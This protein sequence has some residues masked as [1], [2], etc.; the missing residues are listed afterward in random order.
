MAE[1]Q[2]TRGRWWL[3]IAMGLS[4]GL[5]LLDETAVGVALP[6]MQH[7]LGMS[8]TGGHWVINAYLLV[9]TGLV[10]AAGKLGD[11]LDLKRLFL[12]GLALFAVSSIL[13]GFAQS[14]TW[15]IVMRMVQGIGAAI[16]FPGCVA[17]ISKIFKPEERGLAYGIQTGMAGL[18]LCSGPL[19][20]GS[21]TELIS[22]RWIFWINL[23]VVAF[24]SLVVAIL[25]HLPKRE[26]K[27]AGHFDILGLV[28]LLATGVGLITATMQGPDWGWLAAPTLALFA[29]GIAALWAFIK[30]ERRQDDPLIDISLFAKPFFTEA[31]V[32]IFSG[33]FSKLTVV[34]FGAIYLQRAQGLSPIDAGLLILIGVFPSLPMA[35][36]V[37][38]ISDRIGSGRVMLIGLSVNLAAQLTLL[39][40]VLI[41]SVTLFVA[42]ALAWGLALPAHYVAPRRAAMNIVEEHQHGQAGGISVTAQLLGGT[43]AVAVVGAARLMTDSFASLFVITSLLA[44]LVLIAVLK[45]YR[46]IPAGER[47]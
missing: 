3:L 13:C 39:L 14:A 1:Q 40:A 10:T 34:I 45:S 20:G 41:D 37:G 47:P 19:L 21:L 11:L 18:F 27:P 42:A 46:S 23:P 38:R 2:R 28:T 7:D 12:A 31:K 29:V 4:L 26:T 30:V 16:V 36:L 8:R 6:T 44:F 24:L 9:F 33:Q 15:L 43:V 32:T 17:I 5:V 22:W 35:L 25:L